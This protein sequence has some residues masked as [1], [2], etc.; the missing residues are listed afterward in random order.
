MRAGLYEPAKWADVAAGLGLH[1]V[2]LSAAAQE[3]REPFEPF[4]SP[5]RTAAAC[6]EYA[7]RGVTPHV[8][9]WP[10]PE[11]TFSRAMLA[12]LEDLRERCP[13]LGSC[14]LDAEEQWTTHPYRE[15]DGGEAARILREGWPNGLPLGVNGITG[16]L[17]KILD[18]VRVADEVWPQAYS[19]NKP[20]MNTA[21]GKRQLVVADAWAKELRAGQRLSMG[22]AAFDQEGAGGLPA[23]EALERSAYAAASRV[24]RIRYWSL[25]DL[26]AGQDARFVRELSARCAAPGP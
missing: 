11:A 24:E 15:R 12:W 10:R 8:M 14:D 9:L 7:S 20:N 3:R 1:D 2:S 17:Q 18:L 13:E 26:Q 6:R 4:L 22:L 19:A 25:Q 16:A 23:L 21:P 5:A